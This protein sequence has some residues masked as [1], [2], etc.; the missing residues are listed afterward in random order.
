M[1]ADSTVEIG[2]VLFDRL[3]QLDL[4][5]P[6]EILARVPGVDVHV[7]AAGRDPV[8]SDT[9]LAIVPTATFDDC[10]ALDVICVPGG[11][12][13]NEAMLDRRLVDF[14]A[15]QAEDAR[16]ITSVCS[17][18]LVL[19]AAGLLAGRRATTHWASMEF[20]PAFG[21]TPV[22]ERVCI[23]GNVITG[24]G[25]TA[26]I[27][28]GL[29]LAARLAGRQVAERIQ[30]SLEYTPRPPFSAGTPSEAPSQVVAAYRE[31]ADEG[32]AQRAKAVNEAAARLVNSR[33]RHQSGSS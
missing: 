12:G 29:L 15:S 26:G 20:L 6:Y 33:A 5:G 3:T 13:V 9:G 8:R 30:L 18:A 14:V 24:G 31:A 11:P 21:A 2:L 23:D 19:G 28:F 25:V 27:D 17:G 22:D 4:T 10:P 1:A 16:W 7:V 32:L